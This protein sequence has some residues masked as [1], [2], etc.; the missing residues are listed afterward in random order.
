MRTNALSPSERR[1]LVPGVILVI[2][3]MAS[4]AGGAQV[5]C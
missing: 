5:L 2:L 1:D 4:Q 3:S